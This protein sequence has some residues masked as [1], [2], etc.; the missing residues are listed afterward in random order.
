MT[1]Q[2]PKPVWGSELIGSTTTSQLING[3]SL[4]TTVNTYRRIITGWDMI[5]TIAV[6]PY[7]EKGY[8]TVKWRTAASD[9]AAYETFTAGAL[10]FDLSPRFAESILQGSVRF[11]L[12]GKVYVDR[13]GGLFHTIEP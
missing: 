11:E 12:G 3:G 13:L 9:Q 10:K 2:V 6:M 4:N 7:D 5:S 1:V 8:L